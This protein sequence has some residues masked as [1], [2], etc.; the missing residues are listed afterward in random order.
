MNINLDKQT[1][2]AIRQLAEAEERTMVGQIRWLIRFWMKTVCKED[3][4]L[5]KIKIKGSDAVLKVLYDEGFLLNT[6]DIK[7]L[8]QDRYDCDLVNYSSAIYSLRK[9]GYV[10]TNN[11]LHSLTEK[12]KLK[13]KGLVF[14]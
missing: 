13:A 9:R 14:G 10:S 4:P 12:G 5:T 3:V 1:F 2:S 7:D 6:S 11:H 8:V